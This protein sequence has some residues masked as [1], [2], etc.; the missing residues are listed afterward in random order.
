MA[1][2]H[3]EDGAFSPEWI[4]IWSAAAAGV[5]TLALYLLNRHIVSGRKI[6][7]AAMCAAVGIAVFMI[8]VPTPLGPVHLSL[9]PLIGALAGPLLGSLVA[10][11]VNAF[12]AAIGHGGWGM[13]GPNSIVNITEVILGYYSFRLLRRRLKV[14]IFW[15]GFFATVFALTVGALVAVL[16]VA[17]SGIQGSSLTHSE[18]LANTLVLGAVN[19]AAGV[20]EGFVTGYIATFIARVRPDLIGEAAPPREAL[21]PAQAGG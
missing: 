12:S 11:V 21:A 5:L 18:I 15:S 6:A 20:L 16:I 8:E 10:L 3:L 13:I 17:V 7:V 19:V 9:T 4:L 2:I 14:D 1:H